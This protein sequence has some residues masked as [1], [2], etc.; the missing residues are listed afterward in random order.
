[1]KHQ[2]NIL[3]KKALLVTAA[4]CLVIVACTSPEKSE[5]ADAL[6]PRKD[7]LALAKLYQD[8]EK[9]AE[10]LFN[11]TEIFDE[12][13]DR[14]MEKI[15][16]DFEASL[17]GN[18][19][20]APVVELRNL[21]IAYQADML[22]DEEHKYE[23]DIE[24]EEGTPEE[25]IYHEQEMLFQEKWDERL[26]KLLQEHPGF[27]EC[28]PYMFEEAIEPGIKVA[29]SA[30][31][32]LRF[33]TYLSDEWRGVAYVTCIRQYRADNG[34]VIASL[35]RE[36]SSSWGIVDNIHSLTMDGKTIYLQKMWHNE[37]LLFVTYHAEAIEGD[38]ITHPVIFDT[39]GNEDPHVLYNVNGPEKD[40]VARY[41]EKK[42]T[43]Y[44]R[45]TDK[46]HHY[47]LSDAYVTYTFDGK[48]FRLT[49]RHGD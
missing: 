16:T 11:H 3:A 1:M 35:V 28:P 36:G 5:R 18:P 2:K 29:T 7:S 14:K 41:D 45:V 48:M 43:I 30:D 12:E 40:W 19:H 42:K 10:D 23:V 26:V 8:Y 6:L 46:E 22:K 39:E 34:Q 20:F 17:T 31:G 37:G 24:V 21:L 27:M 44:M 25:F 4:V 32:R 47:R 15:K 33:Y 13:Y 38:K 49:G 9:T